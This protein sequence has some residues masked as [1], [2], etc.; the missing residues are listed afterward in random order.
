MDTIKQVSFQQAGGLP[1]DDQLALSRQMQLARALQQQASTPLQANQMVGGRVVPISLAQGLMKLGDGYFA[2]RA[3]DRTDEMARDMVSRQQA[4]RQQAMQGMSGGDIDQAIQAALQSN[5]PMLQQIGMDLWK[6]KMMPENVVVGRSLLNKQT[7]QQVGIDQTWQQEQEAT[8]KAKA[9]EAEANRK[10]RADELTAKNQ[11]RIEEIKMRLED[12][13]TARAEAAALR[14]EMAGLVGGTKPPAGYRFTA[15]GNLEPIP[16]GPA[17][18]KT[19]TGADGMPKLTEAQGKA[20]LYQSRATEADRILSGLE[21]KY[22][23]MAINAKQGAGK[24]WGVGGALETA[25]N[26]AMP[27]NTQKAEQAQ[28]DFVNAVL[29]QESGAVIADSEFANAQKQYFP[30]PGDS[31]AVIEQKRKNRETAI[32]GL[33]VMAG[34]AANM[35]PKPAAD[36]DQLLKKYGG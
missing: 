18:P 20:N 17:D 13:Q 1:A 11:A 28:R 34:P 7:G 31:A 2:G 10:A 4:A 23:P 25:A 21:G 24:V 16:G 27:A 3:Q 22:S 19:K 9:E 32:N 29:R 14:K 33:R 36:I 12:R 35:N 6:K 26:Y 5:D 8:R 15:D 30:Q